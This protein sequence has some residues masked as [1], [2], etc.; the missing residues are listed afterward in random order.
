MKIT[1]EELIDRL[2]RSFEMEEVMAGA[3]IALTQEEQHIPSELPP[4]VRQRIIEIIA[5]IQKD[6]L[7]H[8]A[9]VGNL[10]RELTEGG[11]AV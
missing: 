3:L 2:R 10:V 6:T 11:Y 1:R 8:K 4:E 7:R 9:T 5:S